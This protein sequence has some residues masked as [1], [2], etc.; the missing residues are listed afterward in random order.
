MAVQQ[1][2]I[3]LDVDGVLN[4]GIHDDKAAPLLFRDKDVRMAQKL[5][6]KGYRG[7]EAECG[8]KLTSLASHPLGH[9]EQ[10]TYEML[11][12]QNG[13]ELS[14][15]L[16]GRFAELV[17]FAGDNCKIVLSSSWRRPHH[18]KRRKMLEETI[19]RHLDRHFEFTDITPTWRE[20]R[21]PADR[22][23]TIGDH[24]FELCSK[25]PEANELRVLVLEDFFIS[26]MD[27]WLCG[28][29]EMDSVN[30]AERYLENR[31]RNI[32]GTT[33]VKLYHCYDEITTNSGVSM[34]VGK[35]FSDKFLTEAKAFIADGALSASLAED[36]DGSTTASSQSEGDEV[37]DLADSL[38]GVRSPSKELESSFMQ[39]LSAALI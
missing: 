12:T 23:E 5:A 3:F 37:P 14:D 7:P 11:M 29:Q 34:H 4:V 38:P 27:G 20:E 8:A 32:K 30:A 18:L 28:G 1:T 21:H 33:L 10:G 31:A 35:G 2:V 15:V 17:R 26:A 9:G 19:G 6:Q 25:G 22:L 16:V 24:L 13:A 36:S 39:L